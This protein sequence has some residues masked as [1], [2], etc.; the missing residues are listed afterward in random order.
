MTKRVQRLITFGDSFTYGQELTNPEESSWPKLV[1]N[2][3]NVELKNTAFPGNSND[4]MMEQVLQESYT[5]FDFAIVCFSARTRFYFEDD[6]GWFTTIHEM[7]VENLERAKLTK[8]LFLIANEE[9]LYRRW[10]TQVIYIQE[11]LKS[12]NVKY[13]FANAFSKENYFDL[14]KNKK[15]RHLLDLIN[16]NNF[17]G[18]P[19]ETF[20]SMTSSLPRGQFRHPLEESHA[21]FANVINKNLKNI[22]DLPNNF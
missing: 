7:N 15:Y 19:D 14:Y 8:Q 18:W 4:R 16:T 12:R 13:L 3:L 17:I 1:A 6:K 21:F 11:F 5:F 2:H 22:Y 9:W 10:L 20:N